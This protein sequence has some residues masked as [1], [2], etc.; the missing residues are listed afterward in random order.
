MVFSKKQEVAYFAH[1]IFLW[2]YDLSDVGYEPIFITRSIAH[3]NEDHPQPFFAVH[4]ES[5]S[6]DQLRQ[7]GGS[8]GV[9]LTR[10]L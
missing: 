3:Y 6:K 9:L 2:S 8:A 4:T 5:H 10:D 1:D 7:G